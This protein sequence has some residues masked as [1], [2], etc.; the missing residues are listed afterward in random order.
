MRKSASGEFFAYV[1]VSALALA[2]DVVVLYVLAEG[3]A[4]DKPL[5]AVMAYGVGLL[6]HYALA[7][8]HVFPYRRY[9][10]QRGVEMTLYALA[11]VIGA[12]T[13]YAI[14]FAGTRLGVSLW[15]SKAVA[16]VVSFVLTY[17]TRRR[18]LFTRASSASAT[19]R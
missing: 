16:V 15:S 10:E 18:F 4:L 9:A 17:A 7:V 1:A 8:T 12:I 2:V 5:A 14:V 3:L 19:P 11:G 13:S 6:A